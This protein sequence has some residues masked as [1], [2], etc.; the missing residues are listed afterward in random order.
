[1]NLNKHREFIKAHVMKAFARVGKND[2]ES[3]SRM[4]ILIDDIYERNIDP[5]II[6][7]AFITHA[8]T[9]QFAPT[10]A[11]IMNL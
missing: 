10:L 2:K 11:D 5:S 6:D 4:K 8:E 9:S 1:M 7:R 3:I